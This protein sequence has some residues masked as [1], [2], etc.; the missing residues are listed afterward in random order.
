MYVTQIQRDKD[1]T[2]GALR[3][4]IATGLVEMLSLPSHKML[5]EPIMFVEV[6]V[7]NAWVGSVVADLAAQRRALHL[8]VVS[9]EETNAIHNGGSSGGYGQSGSSKHMVEHSSVVQAQVPLERLL[10]YATA[11]RSLTKGEGV[12]S[13]EY[14]AHLP[15]EE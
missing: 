5:L 15:R 12:F 7:P 2:P 6:S 1:T 10:G 14:F 9:D 13:A 11:L 3:A 8:E 4:A